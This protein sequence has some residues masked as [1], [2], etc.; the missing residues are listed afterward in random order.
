MAAS[1]F[2][3]YGAVGLLDGGVPRTITFKARANISGGYWVLGSS[4]DNIVS[5]GADT[6]AA[7][8]IEGYPMGNQIGS[9]VIGLCLQD[10][11]SGT[12]GT[13]VTR[14]TFILPSMSGTAIGSNYAG[15]PV[16]AGSMGTVCPLGSMTL[17]VNAI[18]GTTTGPFDFKI[19]RALSTSSNAGT[20]FVVVSLN[21]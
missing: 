9:N 5:S 1:F 16:C 6:Y 11:A 19:G 12:Y 7:S 15:F 20:G 3:S 14:G 21:V 2:N 17:L 8:D 10:T 18:P 13:A 4:A